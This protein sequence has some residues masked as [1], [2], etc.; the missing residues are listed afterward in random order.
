MFIF[1]LFKLVKIGKACVSNN[2]IKIDEKAPSFLPIK[3]N[4]RKF[5]SIVCIDVII[6][7]K[8]V[9]GGARG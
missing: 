8:R 3:T 9:R 5:S 2:N 1:T 6:Y 4:G 7:A